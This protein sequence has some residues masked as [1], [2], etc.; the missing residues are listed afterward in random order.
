MASRTRISTGILFVDLLLVLGITLTD[1]D[2]ES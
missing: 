2:A 1:E